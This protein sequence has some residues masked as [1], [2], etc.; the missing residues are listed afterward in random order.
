MKI[1]IECDCGNKAVILAQANKYT[2]F[3]DNLEHQGFHLDA[4]KIKDNKAKEF[5]ILCNKC[6]A[7]IILGVD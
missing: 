5:D 4:P 7:R 1:V 3:R 2:Q 6:R